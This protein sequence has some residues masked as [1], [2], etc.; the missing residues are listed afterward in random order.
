MAIVG[1]ATALRPIPVLKQI[2]TPHCRRALQRI[3]MPFEP[4]RRQ[5]SPQGERLLSC[6]ITDTFSNLSVEFFEP[7]G[8]WIVG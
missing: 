8:S 3:S 4:Q 7:I 6:R 2:V 1:I 5:V